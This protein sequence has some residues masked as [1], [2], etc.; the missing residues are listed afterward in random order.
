M[1]FDEPW[2]S[3]KVTSKKS[4]VIDKDGR[5]VVRVY[6]HGKSGNIINSPEKMAERISSCVNLLEGIKTED[7][8]RVEDML[9]GFIARS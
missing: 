7:F 1:F 9:R 4:D 8:D 3:C 5:V 6:K 2:Y